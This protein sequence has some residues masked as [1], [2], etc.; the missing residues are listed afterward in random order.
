M[1]FHAGLFEDGPVERREIQ[2][3]EVNGIRD[4][5]H[6]PMRAVWAVGTY[7]GLMV[8]L[9]SLVH[10]Y[11]WEPYWMLAWLTITGAATLLPILSVRLLRQGQ[12]DAHYPVVS[13]FKISTD[14]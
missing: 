4:L 2:V 9:T 12:R 6:L 3:H 7:N 11:H 10:T 14:F 13:L 1:I 8:F 5:S